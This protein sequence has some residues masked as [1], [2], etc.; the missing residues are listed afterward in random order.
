MLPYQIGA[1]GQLQEW[2]E[3]F[4]ES[5]PKHRHVSHLYALH[6]GNQIGPQTPKLFNA[7]KRTLQIRGDEGTGWS[8]AWKI[9]FWARLQEGNHAYRLVHNLFQPA[10]S[11]NVRYESWRLMPNMFCAHPPMQ[12]AGNFGGAAGIVEMLLQSQNGEVHLLPA[13]PDAWPDGALKALR[14]R[15]GLEVAMTWAR[16]KLSLAEISLDQAG[17]VRYPLRRVHK[18]YR[19]RTRTPVSNGEYLT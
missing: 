9:C 14:A 4:E 8:R 2:P 16:G 3:D 10:K 11:S 19:N 18:S 15:G 7:V 13:L 5:D 12:I 1:R 17:K 6:P